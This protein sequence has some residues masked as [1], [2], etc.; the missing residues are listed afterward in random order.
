MTVA[1]LLL[2][3]G[4][5]VIVAGWFVFM[6]RRPSPAGP[7][8]V[9]K[10]EVMLSDSDGRPLPVTMWYPAAGAQ[11]AIIANARLVAP[12]PAPLILYMPG[13]GGSRTQSSIQTANLA[14]H[15]F[16]VVA[17][18]DFSADPA[19][20]PDRGRSL[21]LTSDAEL[22]DTIERGE[23]HVLRQAR[24]LLD[25]LGALDDG[26]IPSLAGRIDLARIGVLGYSSG[27]AVGLQA[28]LTEPRII[29]VINVDGALFGPPADRIGSQA[30]FLMSSR[31]AF[32]PE[33]ERTSPN[34]VVRNY[35][36]LSV[37]DLPRNE[38]RMTVPDAYWVLFEAAQHDDLADDLFSFKRSHPFRTNAERRTINT[39]LQD[40]QVAFFLSTLKNEKDALQGVVG[41]NRQSV[42]WISPTSPTPGAA[43]ARQ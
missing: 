19:N 32:P 17:C 10:M 9:G 31:E 35:A 15:G 43:S 37:M 5:A 28:G 24:R 26:R 2:L 6:P 1:R 40:Y 39:A 27:G 23:R 29:S 13:W 30:Y 12:T 11:G 41:R 4:L 7:Q 14:S 22:A 34:P 18:D 3:V 16:V 36:L 8:A 25:L 33:A 38:R 20:D 21:E 42:R